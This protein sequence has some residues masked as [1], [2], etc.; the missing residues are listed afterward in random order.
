[1]PVL[2]DIVVMT[3]SI[4]ILTAN[5]NIWVVP[6]LH[7]VSDISHL[8]YEVAQ[9]VEAMATSRKVAGSICNGVV[10]IFH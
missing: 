2:S 1:M 7:S 5:D 9:L 3:S 6:L 10:G 4:V 8:G